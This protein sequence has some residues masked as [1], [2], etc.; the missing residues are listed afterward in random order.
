MD[1]RKAT[2][3]LFARV[4]HQ[5]LAK[6]LGVS[7]ASVRQARLHSQ[8]NAHR[9]PPEDWRNATIRLAEERVWH[10]RRLIERLREQESE[11]QDG[12]RGK[13]ASRDH[14]STVHRNR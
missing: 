7:V 3:D 5:D 11:L 14:R 8:A 9:S 12:E 13:H 1:F 10:Y 4:T 6:A 2:D